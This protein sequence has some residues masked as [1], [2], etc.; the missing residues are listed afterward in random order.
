ML[1]V[2][3]DIINHSARYLAKAACIATRYCCVRRQTTPA[4]GEPEL[5]V[6]ANPVF[7]APLLGSDTFACM[8]LMAGGPLLAIVHLKCGEL[9]CS[10][11]L[12]YSL[13]YNTSCLALNMRS[14]RSQTASA[15]C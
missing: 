8:G 10:V 6:C 9:W 2:R 1:F 13:E 7:H 11:T 5:Q 15:C 14:R 4:P 3:S 12:W